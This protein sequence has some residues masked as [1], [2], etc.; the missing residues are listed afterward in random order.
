LQPIGLGNNRHFAT[1]GRS[2]HLQRML[3]RAHLL[4]QNASRFRFGLGDE[5]FPRPGREDVARL[6]SVHE[7]GQF[8]GEQAFPAAGRSRNQISVREPILFVGP[9]QISQR[10]CARKRH[11]YIFD[12]RLPVFDFAENPGKRAVSISQI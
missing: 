8:G 2:T 6:C 11:L 3:K 9:S 1:A 12:F 5:N 7:I 10:C 4:N